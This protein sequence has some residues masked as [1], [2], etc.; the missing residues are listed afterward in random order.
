MPLLKVIESTQSIRDKFAF[1]GTDKW[2]QDPDMWEGLDN[3]MKEK[4]AVSF[5]VDLMG[6]QSSRED[7]ID[8]I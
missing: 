5:D 4:R 6:T 3:I 7:G 2:G 1:I 8:Y